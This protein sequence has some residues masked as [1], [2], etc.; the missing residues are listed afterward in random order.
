MVYSFKNKEKEK[1]GIFK[2]HQKLTSI[3]VDVVN[4]ID[5]INNEWGQELGGVLGEKYNSS[6]ETYWSPEL[7]A[8]YHNDV[9]SYY[10]WVFQIGF[11]PF[12]P[13]DEIIIRF[14]SKTNSLMKGVPGLG[15]IDL[16][17]DFF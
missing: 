11:K 17:L 10:S 4:Y 8:N 9:Q 12:R 5:S 13:S 15:F 7:L 16:I 3:G 6:R 1:E 14:S 2:I